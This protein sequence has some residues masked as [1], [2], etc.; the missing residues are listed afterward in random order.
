MK[1]II[2]TAIIM[3]ICIVALVMRNSNEDTVA[4]H[5]PDP[6]KPDEL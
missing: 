2:G 1:D 5:K 6:K 4:E 3:V